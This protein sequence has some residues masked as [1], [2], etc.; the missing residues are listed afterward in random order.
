MPKSKSRGF[1]PKT[2]KAGIVA[3]LPQ[4]KCLKRIEAVLERIEG[5]FGGFPPI[6]AKRELRSRE[7]L[8][9]GYRV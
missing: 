7:H 8:Q 9:E 5:G 2:A 4:K 6:A 1:S 3:Y